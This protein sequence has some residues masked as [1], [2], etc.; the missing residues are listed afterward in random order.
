MR[1]NIYTEEITHRVELVKKGEFT[2]VRFYLELP[3]ALST[4]P[5]SLGAQPGIAH[6]SGPFVHHAGDDDSAAVTF[7]GKR[8]LR[9]ALIRALQLLDADEA[10]ASDGQ[11]QEL[12]EKVNGAC[13]LT[14]AADRK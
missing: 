4:P 7:W 11:I 5:A 13:N 9:G 2:G 14:Q 6:L 8:K 1:V 12:N 3:V 10:P